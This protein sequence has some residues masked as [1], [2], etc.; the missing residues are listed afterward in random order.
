[1]MPGVGAFELRFVEHP[2]RVQASAYE[3]L[4][5]VRAH[6]L[7]NHPFAHTSLPSQW[8]ELQQI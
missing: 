6:R 2:L 1:M 4:M 8:V 5:A 7:F 3:L